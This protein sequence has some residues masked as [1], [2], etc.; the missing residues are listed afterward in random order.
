MH[1]DC[2][3]IKILIML[4]FR[5]IRYILQHVLFFVCGEG[6][7]YIFASDVAHIMNITKYPS[8]LACAELFSDEIPHIKMD[9]K[10]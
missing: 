6:N 3:R 2:F 9:R 4:V 8:H 5:Y 10:L 1:I 7:R